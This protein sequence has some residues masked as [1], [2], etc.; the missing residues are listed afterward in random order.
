MS[1]LFFLR[2]TH[3]SP[4][5]SFPVG[6]IHP[7]PPLAP[8]ISGF[9]SRG[10]GLYSPNKLW[11]SARK[12]H[13]G[14]GLGSRPRERNTKKPKA[15]SSSYKQAKSGKRQVA[16]RSLAQTEKHPMALKPP[17]RPLAYS[18]FSALLLLA[19]VPAGGVTRSGPS[20]PLQAQQRK[21]KRKHE[22]R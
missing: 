2:E 22:A 15:T 13:W 20:T 5:I 7:R 9:E 6:E 8:L 21:Q 3:A 11:R 18:A 1:W 4:S 19:C 14:T 16:R 12:H 10:R 17:H